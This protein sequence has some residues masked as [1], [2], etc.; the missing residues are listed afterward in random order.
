MSFPPGSGVAADNCKAPDTPPGDLAHRPCVLPFSTDNITAHQVVEWLLTIVKHLPSDAECQKCLMG[1]CPQN[2]DLLP[3]RTR[4]LEKIIK[5]KRA[6]ELDAARS[7]NFCN[8]LNLI[9][10]RY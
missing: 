4:C 6:K 8:Y 10:F 7:V 1:P 9:I 5:A 2:L 3:Q